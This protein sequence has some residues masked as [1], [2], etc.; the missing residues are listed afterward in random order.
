MKKVRALLAEPRLIALVA[1]AVPGA[2]ARPAERIACPGVDALPPKG[3]RVSVPLGTAHRDRL[4]RRSG[5]RSAGTGGD[6][7]RRR[8]SAR[9]RAVPAAGGRRPRA[10]GRRVLRVRSGRCACVA[11]PPA[12]R[13]GRRQTRSAPIT[14]RRAG[15]DR[16]SSERRRSRRGREAARS[17]RRC[18]RDACR[19]PDV[20][21]PAA[22]TA[23]APPRSG[24]WR[25]RTRVGSATTSSERD[26]FERR[27]R[28]SGGRW[29]LDRRTPIAPRTLTR[30]AGRRVPAARRS[31]GRAAFRT[32]LL[33]G[34]TGS[35]KTEL[36]LRLARL[37]IVATDAACWCWC[38]R[39]R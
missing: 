1:V 31:R 27:D 8:R 12:S 3:A 38:R 11:M 18:S 29:T 26:P 19:R 35:G 15:L 24:R 10:L 6:P 32:V 20:A 17:A 7:A 4:R 16:S 30:R 25:A 13:R 14:R 28:R 33:H 36:Y 37:V 21:R 22:S 2:R 39:S 5:T 34:V 9:Q 23:S